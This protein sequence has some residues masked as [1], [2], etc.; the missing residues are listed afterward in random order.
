[1]MYVEDACGR[2]LEGAER[3]AADAHDAGRLAPLNRSSAGG[4]WVGDVHLR[5][6]PKGPET[7]SA[8]A[9]DAGGLAL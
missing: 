2:V 8:D 9:H 4:S 1:M 6:V 7:G 5:C 3:G